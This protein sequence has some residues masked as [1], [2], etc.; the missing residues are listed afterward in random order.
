MTAIERQDTFHV[1]GFG[2]HV[3]QL[4]DECVSVESEHRIPTLFESKRRHG[5]STQASAADGA[6]EVP[7][8]D[9]QVVR[10]IQELLVQTVIEPRG[11][12]AGSTRKIG[13]PD[14]ADEQCIPRQREPR[15]GTTF[16]VGDQ[17][18]DTLRRVTRR[19]KH[20]HV[21]VAKFDLVAVMKS[22]E[23]IRHVGSLMDA[24]TERRRGVRAPA[25]RTGGRHAR[26]CR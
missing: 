25:R 2:W 12:L 5:L 17:Q 20:F 21:G 1:G 9:L 13:T 4:F 11:I 8:I 15:V 14:S 22:G 6:G 16:E 23:R 26:A 24:G 18:A 7:G 19:V 3:R 10:Q